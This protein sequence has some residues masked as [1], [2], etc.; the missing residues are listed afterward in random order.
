M[1][2]LR[3]YPGEHSFFLAD[4]LTIREART[5][6]HLSGLWYLEVMGCDCR[7]TM[8]VAAYLL[9]SDALRTMAMQEACIVRLAIDSSTLPSPV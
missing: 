5:R 2:D 6:K 7:P 8:A 9:H 1:V 3:V 4:T